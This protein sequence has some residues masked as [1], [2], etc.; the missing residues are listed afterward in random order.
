MIPGKKAVCDDCEH[1]F[2]RKIDEKHQKETLQDAK[3]TSKV[4]QSLKYILRL[5]VICDADIAHVDLKTD[6]LVLCFEICP[7]SF[8]RTF[9]IKAVKVLFLIE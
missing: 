5:S 4:S 9:Y 3:E 6:E 2:V 1:L 8:L 7:S